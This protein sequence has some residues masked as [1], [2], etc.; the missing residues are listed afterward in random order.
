LNRFIFFHFYYIFQEVTPILQTLYGLAS[1]FVASLASRI[2]HVANGYEEEIYARVDTSLLKEE[3]HSLL[4]NQWRL[5]KT[6]ESGPKDGEEKT[7]Q[8]WPKIHEI[9]LKKVWEYFNEKRGTPIEKGKSHAFYTNAPLSENV[10]ITIAS[11]TRLICLNY[12]VQV[13][14]SVIVDKNGQ[15]QNAKYEKGITGESS[16]WTDEHGVNHTPALKRKRSSDSS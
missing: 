9:Y 8:P 14:R 11:E 6:E 13:N 1:N 2:T 7:N 4:S 10:F 12:E 16:I 3:N 5:V 15:I